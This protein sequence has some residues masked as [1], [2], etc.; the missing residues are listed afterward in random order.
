MKAACPKCGFEGNIKDELIPDAGRSIGCPK[1]KNR[2]FITKS[3]GPTIEKDDE[4]VIDDK[5][6][7]EAV[8]S[9]NQNKEIVSDTV[10]SSDIS[11][12]GTPKPKKPIGV[13]GGC[14]IA[15]V[16][17]ILLA[18]IVSNV[19][20]FHRATKEHD[21]ARIFEPLLKKYPDYTILDSI[22]TNSGSRTEAQIDAYEEKFEGRH[23]IGMGKIEDVEKSIGSS[24][25]EGI[26]GSKT[27]GTVIK[28]KSKNAYVNLYFPNTYVQ[29]YV[30][31]NK[32][33]Y[34]FFAGTIKRISIGLWTDIY[35]EN[36]IIEK[37]LDSQLKELEGSYKPPQPSLETML[38]DNQ[39]YTPSASLEE[40]YSEEMTDENDR[41]VSG[42][43]SEYLIKLSP[44][45]ISIVKSHTN[46]NQSER[47][48]IIKASTG[49]VLSC[50]ESLD[51]GIHA[52]TDS[53]EGQVLIDSAGRVLVTSSIWS[54]LSQDSKEDF[55]KASAV[56]AK[57]HGYHDALWVIVYEQMTD[58]RI[59]FWSPYRGFV[60]F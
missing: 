52:V 22:D 55:I 41:L 25:V 6:P 18:I 26:F 43:E 54:S 5:I 27:A 31:W 33:D 34:I 10:K 44:D 20:G 35:V 8:I 38:E 53:G 1:C 9:I 12:T 36:V 30:S 24:I 59:A 2:F 21:E 60:G 56:Y 40:T 45:E 39:E 15:I 17:V 7:N 37:H 14:L 49:E 58:R 23:C 42:D 50:N 28:L 32:D 46:D 11:R 13:V 19:K 51:A 47:E 16:C 48:G 29:E 3:E 4:F 57:C